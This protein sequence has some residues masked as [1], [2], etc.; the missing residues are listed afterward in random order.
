M[1]SLLKPL[2]LA[3]AALA[4]LAVARPASA[5]TINVS[6]NVPQTCRITATADIDFLDYD[7]IGANELVD[8]TA[9]GSVTF[10]CT[11]GTVPQIT[12]DD[13]GGAAGRQMAGP[14]PEVLTYELYQPDNVTRWGTA[15]AEIYTEAARPSSAPVTRTVNARIPAGQDVTAGAYTDTVNVAILP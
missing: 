5:Q 12:I 13:G 4:V 6:A 7:P 11:R 3:G 8:D 10:R 9:T 15:G 1:K 2:L 14:G